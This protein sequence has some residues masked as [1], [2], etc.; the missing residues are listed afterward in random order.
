MDDAR[1]CII[2]NQLNQSIGEVKYA[3]GFKTKS[4][5]IKKEMRNFADC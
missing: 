2:L 5:K 1:S 4:S 3:D